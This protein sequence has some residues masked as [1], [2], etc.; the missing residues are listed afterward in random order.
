MAAAR[1][2]VEMG[3]AARNAAAVKT[4]QPLAEVVVA[5]PGGRARRAGAACA[6]SC[7]TSST[8]RTLRLVADARRAG[9]LRVKP[10]LR[11]LGPKLGKQ[12]G[13]G[14]GGAASEA[15]RGRA[16]RPCV[17]ALGAAGQAG[18]ALAD[19][20]PLTLPPT[21]SS[22]RPGSPRATRSSRTASRTVAL[23]T[24]VDDELRDEGAGARAR[25]R[26]SARAQERRPCAS[27]TPSAW[28]WQLPAELRQLVE[29][30]AAVIKAET[31]ASEFELETAA[32]GTETPD[33]TAPPAS[34]A[35]PATV[36]TRDHVETAHVEGHELTIG[37]SA[38]GT[39]FTV[40]YG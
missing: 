14:A 24:A 8:S 2:V 25:A 20:T 19:G 6:T 34:T 27:K 26:R 3:R 9:R 7:S 28:R 1:R 37:I 16:G 29:R 32:S 17:A 22:S 30:Y 36:A 23:N 18:L 31:L 33:G 13:A 15:D 12:L 21:S 4:R 40:T 5:L 11:V 39:I 38:T 10:N 35:P